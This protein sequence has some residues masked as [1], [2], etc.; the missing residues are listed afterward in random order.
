MAYYANR[1][2][3]ARMGV[4]QTQE[5]IAVAARRTAKAAAEAA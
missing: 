2:H 1:G 3:L 4:Y 5:M